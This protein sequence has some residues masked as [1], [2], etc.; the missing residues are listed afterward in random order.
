MA[1][2]YLRYYSN[3]G[4]VQGAILRLANVYG[5]G[6]KSSSDDRG[7]INMMMRKA[8]AGESLEV[9]GKG[10]CLRDYIYVEDVISAFLHAGI[11]ITRLNGKHFV[12]GNGEGHSVVQAINLVA[13]RVALKTRKRVSVKHIDPPALQSPIEERNFVAD[14]RR[15]R[16]AT[17]WK[18]RHSLTNGIDQ[19]LE[20]LTKQAY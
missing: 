1:E 9:Y 15:F 14:T 6:P 13:D 4:F 2:K 20:S 16:L 5:P 12:L 18:A 17:S 11:Y 3:Q 10:D 7:I 8:L 19:T